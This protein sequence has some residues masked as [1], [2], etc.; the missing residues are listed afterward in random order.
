MQCL[1]PHNIKQVACQELPGRETARGFDSDHIELSKARGCFL[2]PS[3][4]GPMAA[5]HK[6]HSRPRPSM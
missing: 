2:I 5:I 1:S 6:C 3:F 4:I